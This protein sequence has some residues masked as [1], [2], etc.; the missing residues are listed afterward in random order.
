MN[1]RSG[2]ALS[3]HSQAIFEHFEKF[4]SPLMMGGDA[5]ASSKGTAKMPVCLH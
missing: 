3:E 1:V 5:D 2:G 4:G